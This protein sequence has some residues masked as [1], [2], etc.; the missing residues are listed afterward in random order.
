MPTLLLVHMSWG[1]GHVSPKYPLQGRLS[2]GTTET[3][4]AICTNAHRFPCSNYFTAHGMIQDHIQTLQKVL[5]FWKGGAL[6]N[7]KAATLLLHSSKDHCPG[8]R[9]PGPFTVQGAFPCMHIYL[10]WAT[11]SPISSL[12]DHQLCQFCLLGTKSLRGGPLIGMCFSL[13]IGR[14]QAVM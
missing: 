1:I 12:P 10:K 4:W 9:Y 6:S 5:S 11:F 2:G 8:S 3:Q 14:Q 13:N 7:T